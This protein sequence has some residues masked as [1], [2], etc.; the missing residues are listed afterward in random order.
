ME[1]ATLSK[2]SEA[3]PATQGA[4][5][6]VRWTWK[7]EALRTEKVNIKLFSKRAIVE[8]IAEELKLIG[9]QGRRGPD[10]LWYRVGGRFIR[11]SKYEYALVTGLSFG[12]MTFDPSAKHDPPTSGLFLRHY[13]GR[14]LKMDTLRR[15]FTDGVFRGSPADALQVPTELLHSMI[16]SY[17][18]HGFVWAFLI[19]AFEAVPELRN[20]CGV[21]TFDNVLSRCLRWRFPK[22][23]QV[24]MD[25]FYDREMEV[26]PTLEPSA[27]EQRQ[28]YWEHIQDDLRSGVC[29]V[30]Q[31]NRSMKLKKTASANPSS[32]D[33][34]LSVYRPNA[35]PMI[36]KRKKADPPSAC[37]SRRVAKQKKVPDL[38]DHEYDAENVVVLLPGVRLTSNSSV[39]SKKGDRNSAL[40]STQGEDD[41]SHT[42]KSSS[43]SQSGCFSKTARSSAAGDITAEILDS[44]DDL[45]LYSRMNDVFAR[46]GKL[47]RKWIGCA[48][49]EYL[50]D[51]DRELRLRK[52]VSEVKKEQPDVI[53]QC[54]KLATK[55]FQIYCAPQFAVYYEVDAT[56]LLSGSTHNLCHNPCQIF[57]FTCRPHISFIPLML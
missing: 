3:A 16:P 50:I 6:D 22:M 36:G 56:Y 38:S 17:R 27:D 35:T 12:P 13:R 47:G 7:R 2:A 23:T 29:Y 5:E 14:R 21:P 1:A 41:D 45:L 53:G 4:A 8:E 40:P 28:L 54:R 33:I 48:L 44:D 52:S 55:L 31:D 10:D 30:H 18:L 32:C 25:G 37:A 49:A 26:Y 43:G 15:D 19:W 46:S 24:D 39:L 11:F 42:V 20:T 9:H 34:L 51:G 57:C